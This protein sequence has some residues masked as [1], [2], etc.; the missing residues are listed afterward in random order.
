MDLDYTAKFLDY[1][2]ESF[3]SSKGKMEFYGGRDG[4]L[5]SHPSTLQMPEWKCLTEEQGLVPRP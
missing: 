1:F 3:G 5:T 4:F 2:I